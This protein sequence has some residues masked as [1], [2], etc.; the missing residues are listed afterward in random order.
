VYQSHV[1]SCEVESPTNLAADEP[2]PGRRSFGAFHRPPLAQPQNQWGLTPHACLHAVPP[3]ADPVESRAPGQ[4]H[5]SHTFTR[6]SSSRGRSF[7]SCVAV[8]PLA[9]RVF[10]CTSLDRFRSGRNHL[11]SPPGQPCGQPLVHGSAYSYLCGSHVS[12]KS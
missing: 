4:P 2:L 3:V 10:A 5:L 12:S 6:T 9:S 11:W 7:G 8:Q 1:E